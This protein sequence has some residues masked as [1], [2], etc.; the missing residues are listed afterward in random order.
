MPDILIMKSMLRFLNQISKAV[1]E[2][3]DEVQEYS[4]DND[5]KIYLLA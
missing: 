4:I 2:V 1:K 5:K 3:R